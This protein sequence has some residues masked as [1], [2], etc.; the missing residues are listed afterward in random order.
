MSQSKVLQK[1]VLVTGGSGFIGFH[2]CKALLNADF[3]VVTIDNQIPAYSGEMSK[4][5]A[6]ILLK[7]YGLKTL[8]VDLSSEASIN[9]LEDL[10]SFDVI[11]HLAA[12][13][14][15]R[16][17]QEIPNKYSKNNIGVF[18]NILEFCRISK[19]HKIYFASS[20]SVYG[21]YASSGALRENNADGK[22]LK[23]YYATTK[24]VNEIIAIEYKKFF[25][26]NSTALRFFTV[27]GEY[28]R[29]DMAYWNFADSIFHSKEIKL[30]GQDGGIRNFTYVDD[31]VYQLI[32]LADKSKQI[33]DDCLN[34]SAGNPISTIDI[35]K[36]IEIELEPKIAKLKIIE[37]PQYDVD[38][39]WADNSR[40]RSLGIDIKVTE[41]EIGIKRFIDW[42][43]GFEFKA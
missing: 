27:Y 23:S 2:L 40:A 37:R 35:L 24:W 10:G 14:G 20:S 3:N 36:Q 43:K 18:I 12:W 26:V 30:F 13:P 38:V 15:V 11:F 7:D 19:S 1:R 16:L 4:I 39:T 22:N 42:F 9:K 32:Q 25:G 34:I 31:L 33:D 6:N 5:R 21:D 28:G 29:P 41:M 17:S 8:D